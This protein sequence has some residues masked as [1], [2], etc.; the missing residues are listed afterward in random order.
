MSSKK[1]YSRRD[2]NNTIKEKDLDQEF[3][4]LEGFVKIKKS[5]RGDEDG[6]TKE[7]SIAKDHA[8]KR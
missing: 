1:H 5:K 3:D 4:D 2:H 6:K 8:R 7:N